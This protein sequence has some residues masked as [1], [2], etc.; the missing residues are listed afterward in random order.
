MLFRSIALGVA[1]A[2]T[3]GAAAQGVPGRSP[4]S[5]GTDPAL[6]KPPPELKGV[7]SWRT[8]AQVELV[9]HK[10]RYV[11]Q[12]SGNVIS[13]DK[14][15]VKVQGFMLPLGVG[16]KQTHFILSAMPM[17]CSFCMPGGPEQMVEVKSKTPVKY[18]FEPVL[19]SGRLAV[20]KD[21]PSGVFYRLTDAVQV[22]Q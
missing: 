4:L 22:K 20:L 21:D 6:L 17:T 12:F 18:G 16:D 19:V 8:L 10:D 13:L 1:A 9:R 14:T 11:P 7:L 3:A 15:E 5:P 2:W